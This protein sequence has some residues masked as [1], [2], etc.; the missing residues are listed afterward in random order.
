MNKP[1]YKQTPLGWMPEDW[2]MQELGNIT[3][4]LTNG[5]V[6]KA[7]EH[8][9]N[10][11]SAVTYI[12][13]YN[14][15]EGGFNFNGIKKVSQA[16]HERNKKSWLK[17]GDLLTIQTGD[18]GVTSLVPKELEGSNCHALI[19][20]RYIDKIAVP[21]FFV[22]YFNSP[23]GRRHLKAIE[24]GSTMKHLNVG[25]MVHLTVPLPPFSEQSRIAAILYTWDVA[26][27]K[28][29]QLIEALQTRHRAIT[30]QLLNGKKRLNGFKGAWKQFSI[31]DIGNEISLKNKADKNIIVLSCTKHGGLVPSIEYFGRKIFSN[32]LS[33]YKIVPKYHFAYATNHIEEGS[34]GYQDKHDEG[35]ISPMYTVFKTNGALVNDFLL[36]RLLKTH[37][38]IIEYRRRMEGSIDRRGGLRWDEFSKIAILIPPLNEQTAIASI[39]STTEKEIQIHRRRLAALQK[40]KKG[41]M[42]V[43]LTGKI[44]VKSAEP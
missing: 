15:T 37:R 41:L 26:I 28:E 25:D 40:Q 44:R 2:E 1:G 13:G 21:A 20:S 14:V 8:Y 36:F 3:E 5:F 30:Q 17:T 39:L 31:G 22:Q 42:Q 4:L 33:S 29:Q 11:P 35:L 34:I 9:D 32:D 38:Y 16:F 18:I 7:T 19:I 6:G 27:A 43:L 10:S 23:M 24:T 12:Q